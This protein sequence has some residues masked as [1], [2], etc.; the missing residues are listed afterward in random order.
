MKKIKICIYALIILIISYHYSGCSSDS[1]LNGGDPGGPPL[2]GGYDKTE[3]GVMMTLSALC[4]VAEGSINAMQMRDSI[5]HQLQDTSYATRGNWE[6]VWGPGLSLSGG[7][8]LYV[9]H[10]TTHAG[11]STRYAIC[12]RG[13]DWVFPSNIQEDMEVWKLLKYPYSGSV[14]DSVSYGSLLGL[15]TLLSTMD[16]LTGQTLYAFLNGINT[17]KKKMFITGHSL[18]GA[19]AT[20]L[21]AWFVDLGFSNTYRPEIYTFAAPTVGN[22]SFVNHFHNIMLSSSG[23]SHRCINNKDL[24]PYAWAGIGNIVH[25]GVPTAVP[26]GL[27]VVYLNIQKY[28]QDSG[29]VYKHVDTRQF[30]GTMAAPNCG[31]PGTYE[32]YFCWVGFEHST[33]TYLQLLEVDTI[34]WG[35]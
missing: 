16:P 18:G 13:T 15:D 10:D 32:N 21:A 35:R 22:Q 29:I 9:A 34:K 5:I 25:D 27:Q 31:T 3:A 24:V 7:N 11:D 2:F 14:N 17:P 12:V 20:L 4:Y 19:L 33:S 8:M 6:L 26:V 28:L 23:E 30:L 1:I